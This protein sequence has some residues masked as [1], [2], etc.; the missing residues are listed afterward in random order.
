MNRLILI[1]QKHTIEH[2]SVTRIPC[3]LCALLQTIERHCVKNIR[4]LC[5]LL[6]TYFE[7]K[8]KTLLFWLNVVNVGLEL[9]SGVTN[10][11]GVNFDSDLGWFSSYV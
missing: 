2:C 1:K 5:V 10:D 3:P 9:S 6:C 8:E 7:G 11:L 4:S